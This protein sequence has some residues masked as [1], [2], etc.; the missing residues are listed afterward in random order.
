MKKVLLCTLLLLLGMTIEAREIPP[1]TEFLVNDYASILQSGERAQLE[2]YLRRFAD[3]SSTQI[4]MVLIPSLEGEEIFDYSMRWAQTWGIGQEGKNNG[5]LVFVA[6]QERK[7]RIQVGYGLEGVLTDAFTKRVIEEVMKPSFKAG[8]YYEGLSLASQ[9][10]VK[11]ARGEYKNENFGKKS[12]RTGVGSIMV[13]LIILAVLYFFFRGGGGSNYG[14]R[15]TDWWTAAMLGSALGSMGGSRRSSW[16][17][18]SSGS[19][20]FGG[21]GGGSFGGGGSGGNW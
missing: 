8:N 14:S 2:N 20:S 4:A 6:L 10:L 7:I 5:V 15:G 17:D 18:F 16:G 9:Y 19:G 12:K 21:F 1:K 11:A 13:L 3:S